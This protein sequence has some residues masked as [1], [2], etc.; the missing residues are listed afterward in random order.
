MNSEP[1][2]PTE[3]LVD[4]SLM[5][6]SDFHRQAQHPDRRDPLVHRG[7]RPLTLSPSLLADLDR[8][9]HKV[10]GADLLDVLAA[11]VR[12]A[13]P[14][15]VFLEL[16]GRVLPL[17]LFPSQ[18][19]FACPSDFLGLPEAHLRLLRVARVEPGVE[20]RP[21]ASANAGAFSESTGALALLLWQVAMLGLRFEPLP[22]IIGRA[23]YRVSRSLALDLLPIDDAATGLLRRMRR[24]SLTL[25]D[26]AAVPG[27]GF[28]RACRLLN[29]VY[30][31]A[32][33][34]TLRTSPASRLPKGRRDTSGDDA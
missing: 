6:A 19:V 28:E 9:D 21:L 34:I 16:A 3:P 27:V 14:L 5:S 8:F 1:H 29:A 11:C 32:G 10:D 24:E 31:Q 18:G 7:A 30:L 15:V 2:R 4:D 20:F 23:C 13:R 17:R 25:D 22:E 33:L 26:I 12:H